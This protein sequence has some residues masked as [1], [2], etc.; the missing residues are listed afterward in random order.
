V[1]T[2]TRPSLNKLL[3]L[4]HL[5]V[6]TTSQEE[7]V[8]GCSYRVLLA[9]T[10]EERSAIFR[11][12]FQVFNLELNEGIDAA[13]VTG[14]DRDKFDDVCSLLYVQDRESGEVVGTYRVQSGKTAAAN[15]GY[16]SEQE[17]KFGVFEP[18]RAQVMELGRACIA[19]N[20]R[21]FE[22]LNILWRGLTVY[23]QRIGARYLL[24]CSSLSS[25]NPAEGWGVYEQ[26]RNCMAEPELQTVPQPEFFLPPAPPSAD[27]RVPRL[28]RA[29]LA[30]GA[31]ICGTPAM[32]R[33]FKTIDFLTL[34][35][36][37]NISPAAKARFLR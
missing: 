4:P 31:L 15:S 36:F 17:F 25:Q 27:A 12:R 26:L 29:Y 13:F 34:L 37:E 5:P 28:L 8:R 2:V 35:D 22:V 23:A 20:H 19:R 9:S 3:S 21:S 10:E 33:E 1:A 7:L 6:A 24:G 30:V 11:L 14:E 32:D 18:M 16:Y